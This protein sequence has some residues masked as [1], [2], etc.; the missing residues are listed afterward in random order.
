MNELPPTATLFL[1][2]KTVAG[3]LLC[4]GHVHVCMAVVL[5]ARLLKVRTLSLNFRV[6]S[7]S[8]DIA[9]AL[10]VMTL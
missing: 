6:A 5:T 9:R 1:L 2:A 4:V 10:P 7:A 3:S 8:P